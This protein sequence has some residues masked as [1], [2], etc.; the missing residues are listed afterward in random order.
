L[1]S[2]QTRV[3][4]LADLDLDLDLNFKDL[5]TSLV[6]TFVLKSNFVAVFLDLIKCEIISQLTGLSFHTNEL[7]GFKK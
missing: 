4:F 3:R 2:S 5:T 7:L 1:D 6:G